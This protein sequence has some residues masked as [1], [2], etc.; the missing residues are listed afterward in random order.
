MWWELIYECLFFTHIIN[1]DDGKLLATGTGEQTVA[2]FD[3]RTLSKLMEVKEA[4]SFFVTALHFTAD[5]K[6]ILSVSADNSCLI[7]DIKPQSNTSMCPVCIVF[8]Y[9]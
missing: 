2:V 6:A 5:S 3:A 4:H 9:V 1:S 8:V 7:T